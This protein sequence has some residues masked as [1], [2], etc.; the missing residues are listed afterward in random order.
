MPDF[1][2]QTA[3]C[4]TGP[5][6][7]FCRIG[8]MGLIA[9]LFPEVVVPLEVTEE[10][11][12]TPHADLPEIQKSLAR[13]SVPSALVTPEPFLAMQLDLGEAAVI[14]TAVQ[15]GG[16]PV[17]MDERKGRRVASV[18]YGLRVKGSGGLLVAAKQRGLVSAIKPLLLE[19]R[20][21]GYFL[22]DAL[23]A[24]C[25]RIAGE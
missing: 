19:M 6:L 22:S 10:L 15:R 8:R 11:L 20:R 3:V 14:A 18:G 21:N 1:F 7:A 4:N 17:I 16:L 23:V 9:D 13:F 25:L 24:E 5:L 2:G 12:V